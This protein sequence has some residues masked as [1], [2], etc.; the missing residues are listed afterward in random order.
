MTSLLLANIDVLATMNDGPSEGSR[1]SHNAGCGEELHNA[2]I[3]IENGA[4]K[5]VGSNASLAMHA[6]RV[7]E[8]MN[9]S[10][11]IVIPGLVNTHH[12]LFQNL[13]RLIPEAQNESLFGWLK[14]LYP[15]WQQLTPDDI[16][17]SAVI[18]L[19]E[20]ALS[21]CTTSS[22]HLYLYPNGSRLDDSIEAA[23]DVG[24][25]FTATRGSMSIGESKGGLPPDS[26]T[27]QEDKILEDCLRVIDAF[28]D[29]RPHAMTRIALAP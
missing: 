18:G 25:R 1:P 26:L 24:I 10:G 9:L 8:V 14:T 3:L 15:I 5:E 2:A 20:L 11:H 16:Y 4:I 23:Q 28:H 7:D 27:E 6:A 13:T 12:H 17:I 21:G 19:S 29:D 22:D